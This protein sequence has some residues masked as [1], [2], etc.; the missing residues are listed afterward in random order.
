MK[1]FKNT[2]NNWQVWVDVFTKDQN[3]E[4]EGTEEDCEKFLRENDPNQSYLYAS[5][6]MIAPHTGVNEDFSKFEC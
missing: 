3:L 2:S 6:F 1:N 4:L 5:V